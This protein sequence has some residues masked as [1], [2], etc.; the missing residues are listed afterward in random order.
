MRVLGS[1]ETA[2]N[3]T[4]SFSPLNLVSVAL[5]SDG[6]N[7][8]ALRH[9]L[10]AL[11]AR[12]PELRVGVGQRG[13]G[14]AGPKFYFLP[15]G[16]TTIPLRTVTPP[17]GDDWQTLVADE[18]NTRLPAASGPLARCTY[19]YNPQSGAASAIVL[20]L[21]HTIIDG[22]SALGLWRELLT[23]AA[24]LAPDGAPGAALPPPTE[25][26]YPRRF[27]GLRRNWI[28]ARFMAAQMS[29]E[30][31]YQ[32]RLGGGRRPLLHPAGGCGNRCSAL[33]DRWRPANVC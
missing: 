18:L 3:L 4:D 9:G 6:P 31:A 25:Q 32:W 24:G 22:D 16:S 12:R 14:L 33:A 8:A 13:R 15:S 21:Q 28:V 19:L 5:L 29:A 10:E 7:P 11:H 30:L 23:L 1:M 27:R 17:E 26:L 20:T 2:L